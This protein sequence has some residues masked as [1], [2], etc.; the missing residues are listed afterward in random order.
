MLLDIGED[1]PGQREQLLEG[2][3]RGL[4]EQRTVLL[5]KAVALAL[6]LLGRAVD[7]L[8]GLERTDVPDQ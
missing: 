3:L 5:G 4:V 6:D 8:T 2:R 7:L 1:R